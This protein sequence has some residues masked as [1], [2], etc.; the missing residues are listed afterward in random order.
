MAE[1]DEAPTVI[2]HK[3]AENVAAAPQQE[4]AAG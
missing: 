2:E 1:D 4:K 3:P